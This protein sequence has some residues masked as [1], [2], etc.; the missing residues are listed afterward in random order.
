MKYFKP[1]KVKLMDA[2]VSTNKKEIYSSQIRL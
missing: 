2:F 1:G